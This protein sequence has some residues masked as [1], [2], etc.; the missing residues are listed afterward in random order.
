MVTLYLPFRNE[1]VD[2][3][4]RDKFLD[5][6]ELNE[7]L[8]HERGKE[9]EFNLDID[10]VLKEIEALCV[11][12][13]S[14]VEE[15]VSQENCEEMSTN[16]EPSDDDL[17]ES[18][19]SL[20]ISARR[21][22]SNVSSKEDYCAH[23]RQMNI[24]QRELILEVIHRLHSID[25]KPLQIFLTGPAGSGKTFLLKALMETYNRYT[26]QHNSMNNAYVARAT[27]GK[28]AVGLNGLTVH[29]AFRLTTSRQKKQLS[30]EVLQTYRHMLRNVKCV[31]IDEISMCSSALFHQVNSR[32]QE[33]A[34]EFTTTFGGL[35]LIACGDLK[36]LPPV[37]ALPVY[38][39]TQQTLGRNAL[40]WQS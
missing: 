5:I 22:R 2:I 14:F 39:V 40:L 12:N 3:L 13:D 34:G 32:L 27:T 9:F 21:R 23:L 38:A 10:E 8:I 26:Q 29:T 24:E 1:L 11:M 37:R 18:A 35:D 17:N 36:Q 7:R 20:P 33:I 25:R 16:F 4:D 31:I 19:T 15:N 30:Y 28:A 6:Y